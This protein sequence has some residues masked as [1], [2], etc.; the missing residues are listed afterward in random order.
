MSSNALSNAP[1]ARSSSDGSLPNLE[2]RARQVSGLLN[3][4]N[5]I[6]RKRRS[7]TESLAGPYATSLMRYC[8]TRSAALKTLQNLNSFRMGSFVQ[9]SSCPDIRRSKISCLLAAKIQYRSKMSCLGVGIHRLVLLF[10]FI[11]S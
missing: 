9:G 11:I 1:D 8:D 10:F 3:V 5:A 4:L 7:A 2:I 6:M